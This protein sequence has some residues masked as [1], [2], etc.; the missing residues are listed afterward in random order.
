MKAGAE[1]ELRPYSHYA[2]K[3]RALQSRGCLKLEKVELTAQINARTSSGQ[4]EN[5]LVFEHE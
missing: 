4:N 3:R 1:S 2:Q 5:A